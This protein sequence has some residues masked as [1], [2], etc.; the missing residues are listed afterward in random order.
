MKQ[1][2]HMCTRQWNCAE[3]R[4]DSESIFATEWQWES[5]VCHTA[6]KNQGGRVLTWGGVALTNKSHPP[7][8]THTLI[9]ATLTRN[10]AHAWAGVF[11][12]DGCIY[13]RWKL[14]WAFL[15]PWDCCRRRSFFLLFW[16]FFFLGIIQSPIDEDGMR[17]SRRQ[18]ALSRHLGITKDKEGGLRD[19]LKSFN[20][21][22]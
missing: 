4:K 16:F 2:K 8:H 3:K 15:S 13:L 10:S 11:M 14:A 21:N 9:S 12:C 22:Q 5:P 19:I 17:H 20:F 6:G 7:T 1:P 18:S